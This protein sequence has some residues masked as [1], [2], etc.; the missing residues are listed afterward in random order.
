MAQRGGCMPISL[1]VDSITLDELA[2]VL[3]PIPVIAAIDEVDIEYVLWERRR[4]LNADLQDAA[5]PTTFSANER[6]LPVV[7]LGNMVV[8]PR[9]QLAHLHGVRPG[10]SYNAIQAALESNRE[11]LVIFVA[12]REI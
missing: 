6:T 9:I 10:R 8:M 2:T 12:E 11:V 1:A 4:S 3:L 5:L 7:V